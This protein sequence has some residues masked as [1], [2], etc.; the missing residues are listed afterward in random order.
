MKSRLLYLTSPGWFI[1]DMHK[2]YHSVQLAF[3]MTDLRV[4]L[5]T[6]SEPI[7]CSHPR[8]RVSSRNYRD[9]LMQI[10]RALSEKFVTA[11]E[12]LITFETRGDTSWQNITP[13]GYSF[14]RSA[15]SRSS[16]WNGAQYSTS[17]AV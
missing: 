1:D 16:D 9:K 3:G 4:S 10:S 13:G 6:D 2:K 8:L 12:L 7:D 11:K 14:G 5:L 17:Q 15:A